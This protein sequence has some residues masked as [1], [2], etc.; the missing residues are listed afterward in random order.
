VKSECS[1]TRS[2]SDDNCVVLAGHLFQH[3]AWQSFSCGYGWIPA[4][5]RTGVPHVGV[6]AVQTFANAADPTVGPD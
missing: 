3:T 2:G 5:K 6:Q 1:A 4:D